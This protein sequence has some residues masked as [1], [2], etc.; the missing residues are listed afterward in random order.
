MSCYFVMFFNLVYLK[1][2]ASSPGHSP[3]NS[4]LFGGEWPGDEAIERPSINGA[5]EVYL[6]I[7]NHFQCIIG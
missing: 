3:P 7:E 5:I 6:A 2:L 1:G 4:A